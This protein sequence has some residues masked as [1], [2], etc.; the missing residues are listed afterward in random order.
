MQRLRVAI[1]ISIQ[2]LPENRAP[3]LRLDSQSVG[4]IALHEL[5]PSGI[6][7]PPVHADPR[8][9]RATILAVR[10]ESH[11]ERRNAVLIAHDG[12]EM[13]E[14]PVIVRVVLLALSVCS[15]LQIFHHV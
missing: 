3:R 11:E 6:F 13:L 15:E 5:A 10:L 14:E 2:I 4:V 1:A 12:Y 8:E 7:Q 9:L